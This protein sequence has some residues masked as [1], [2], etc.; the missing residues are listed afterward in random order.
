MEEQHEGGR[1]R[2]RRRRNEVERLVDEFEASG[3]S[4][5]VFCRGRGLAPSTLQ[6]HLRARRGKSQSRG[7]RL[8]AVSVGSSAETKGK[9][10]RS[11]QTGLEVLL[12]G[13]VRIGV[14]AGFDPG[15]LRAL[16]SVLER[17]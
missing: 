15:T 2:I 1:R 7:C 13:G 14:R 6:R 10:E 3:L 9:S 17:A 4:P 5:T 16:I 11:E 12:P 8:V